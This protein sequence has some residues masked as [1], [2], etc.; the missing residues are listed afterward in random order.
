MSASSAI[1]TATARATPAERA[2]QRII[3]A[4]SARPTSI[5]RWAAFALPRITNAVRRVLVAPVTMSVSPIANDAVSWGYASN[6]IRTSNARARV[7]ER[8]ALI[9]G[10]APL[11]DPTRIAPGLHLFATLCCISASHAAMAAIAAAAA[12][13]KVHTNATRRDGYATQSNAGVVAPTASASW[14]GRG[15][16]AQTIDVWGRYIG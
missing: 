8:G 6:V 12:A 3:V 9:A 15:W 2:V 16:H 13:T 14:L 5:V 11:A 7:G 4:S 1:K 10:T